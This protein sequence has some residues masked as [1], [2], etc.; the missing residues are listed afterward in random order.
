MVGAVI[1]PVISRC[2]WKGASPD[3]PTE[4]TPPGAASGRKLT[5]GS[6]PPRRRPGMSTDH[7]VSLA[8]VRL[9][10]ALRETRDLDIVVQ[11]A[12]T[13]SIEV[14]AAALDLLEMVKRRWAS[15]PRER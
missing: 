2:P 5:E 12:G 13:P 15:S 8:E 14:A 4:A 10:A 7:D 9:V 6:G 1:S 3:M 11:P